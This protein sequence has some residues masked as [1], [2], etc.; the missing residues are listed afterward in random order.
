[1]ENYIM[2]SIET[3]VQFVDNASDDYMS[4]EEREYWIDKEES[5]EEVE[6]EPCDDLFINNLFDS[7]SG[8]KTSET[9]RVE[10]IKKAKS[11]PPV[12][13]GV[14]S[15]QEIFAQRLANKFNHQG[16]K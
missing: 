11:S 6:I 3:D 1:M 12:P 9:T 15:A 14:V 8:D 10:N 4:D 13:R 5:H 7:Y 16:V 2:T